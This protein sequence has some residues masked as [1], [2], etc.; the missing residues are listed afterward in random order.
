MAEI[1]LAFLSRGRRS[2]RR[3]CAKN[4]AR[5]RETLHAYACMLCETVLRIPRKFLYYGRSTIISTRVRSTKYP[6]C[7]CLRTHF[8]IPSGILIYQVF[9]LSQAIGFYVKSNQGAPKYT[10]LPTTNTLE[11][12]RRP[13]S[14]SSLGDP[15]RQGLESPV[16]RA[17]HSDQQAKREQNSSIRPAMDVTL[18]TLIRHSV[19]T[20]ET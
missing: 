11:G 5:A 20:R 2:T 12:A 16:D 4:L 17:N 3:R 7:A 10:S 18:F 6:A 8:K 1:W 13:S 9:F 19:R 15:A 14:A